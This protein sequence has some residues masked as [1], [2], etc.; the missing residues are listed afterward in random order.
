MSDNPAVTC[1]P[2]CDISDTFFSP[3]Q[4]ISKFGTRH[5]E[6]EFCEKLSMKCYIRQSFLVLAEI[7]FAIV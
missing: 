3:S 2:D 1:F 6:F 4:P 7:R 5:F